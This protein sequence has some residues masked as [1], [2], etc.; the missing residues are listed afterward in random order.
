MSVYDVTLHYGIYSLNFCELLDA[1]MLW[2]NHHSFP[3][4]EYNYL[5]DHPLK[6]MPD[7]M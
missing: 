7:L 3:L 4:M 1:E 2:W 5:E 6:T